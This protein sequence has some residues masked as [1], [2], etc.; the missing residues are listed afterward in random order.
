MEQAMTMGRMDLT[1]AMK[2]FALPLGL[3]SPMWMA[4]GAAVS[5]SATWWW[6]SRMTRFTAPTVA[7][8]VESV[9]K[10]VAAP[11]VAVTEAA[12]TVVEDAAVETTAF[13]EAPVESVAPTV[14]TLSDILSV[15]PDELTLLRGVGPRVAEAFVARGVTT[16]AQLAAWTDDQMAAFDADSKLLGRSKRYDFIGQAKELSATV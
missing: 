7:H 5:V 15:Q 4:Y 1:R 13:A 11:V 8:A 12:P 3:A 10:A 14:A 9:P 6:M 2:P 16:F